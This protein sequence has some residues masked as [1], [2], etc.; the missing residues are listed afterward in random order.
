VEPVVN[1]AGHL[2]ILLKGCVLILI[3]VLL[4]RWSTYRFSDKKGTVFSFTVDH[5]AFTP[6]PPGIYAVI[7]FDGGGRFWFDVTDCDPESIEIGMPVEMSFRRRYVDEKGGIIGY[8]WKV[9]PI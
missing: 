7:D 6:N 4:I 8:F 9:V 3:A 2:N 1:N 5:L